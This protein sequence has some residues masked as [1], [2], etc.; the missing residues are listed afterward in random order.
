MEKKTFFILDNGDESVCLMSIEDVAEQLVSQVKS[1]SPADLADYTFTITS[2]QM[3]QAE[4][5]A[6]PEAD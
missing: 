4:F 2:T 5:E 3:T 6:M 1:V